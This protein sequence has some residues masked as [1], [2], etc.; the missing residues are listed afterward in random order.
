MIIMKIGTRARAAENPRA[1]AARTNTPCGLFLFIQKLV[2]S[3]QN[4]GHAGMF[5]TETG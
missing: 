4:G 3:G 2:E 5:P 1:R